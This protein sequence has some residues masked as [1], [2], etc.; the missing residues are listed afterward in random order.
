MILGKPTG[1]FLFGIFVMIGF[2]MDFTYGSL[3]ILG[4]IDIPPAYVAIEVFYGTLLIFGGMIGLTLFYGLWTLKNWVRVILQIG[5][6]A[7]VIFNIII[8]PTNYDNYFLLVVS[9]IVAI[10]LQLS[11]TRNHF[12]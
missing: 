5:F 1:V 4:F 3:M 6:P 7:Q 10:Y 9:I 8:D 2:C 11:S 12:K